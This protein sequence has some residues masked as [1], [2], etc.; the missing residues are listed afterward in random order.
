MVIGLVSASKSVEMYDRAG[1]G[2]MGDDDLC[3]RIVATPNAM[4]TAALASRI[5]PWCSTSA[6]LIASREARASRKKIACAVAAPAPLA[7]AAARPSR[8]ARC[9]QSTEIGPIGTATAK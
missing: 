9:A 7:T 4:I 2:V 1:G 6:K 3:F 5:V 8:R